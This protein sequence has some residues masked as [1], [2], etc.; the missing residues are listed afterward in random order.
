M[1]QRT[2]DALK[3]R[4]ISLKGSILLLKQAET[5]LE[6]TNHDELKQELVHVKDSINSIEDEIE[7]LQD[8]LADLLSLV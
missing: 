1:I 2:L 4:I 7:S 8:V 6:L 5:L 3:K